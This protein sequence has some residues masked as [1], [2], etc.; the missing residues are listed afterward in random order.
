MGFFLAYFEK[1]APRAKIRGAK[2]EAVYRARWFDPRTGEWRD[3]GNGR[4]TANNIG[5]LMLPEFPDAEDWG[6]SLVREE[7]ATR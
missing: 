6:L 1:G 3:V 5:E 7:A 2:P 4:L